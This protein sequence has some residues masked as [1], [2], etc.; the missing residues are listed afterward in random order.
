M[1]KLT[2]LFIA[3]VLL[4]ACTGTGKPDAEESKVKYETYHNDYYDYTVEYP[5][6]LIPQG[7]ATNQDGQKFFS[8]DQKIQLLVYRDYKNDFLTGGD[9]YMISEAYEEDLKGKEEIFNKELHDNHYTIE[10][11]TDDI[12]HTDYA[13]LYGE[14]Y[15]NI[16]FE[17]PETEK[18]RMEAIVEH[19]IKSFKVEDLD[20]GGDEPEGNATAGELEDSFPAFLEGFLKDCYWGKNF[21]T[22]LRNNDKTL[23]TYLDPRMDVRRYYAPG[24]VAILATRDENF[25][26]APED[27]F[28][29]RPS[30]DGDLIFEYVND[31]S[32][33]CELIYSNINVIY[34]VSIKSVPD[35]VV[36]RETLETRP[37]KI[38]YPEAQIMAV[39]LP[40]A[41]DNPVGYYFMHTPDGWKLAFVDDTLCG[42]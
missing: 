38:A 11:K 34:Y 2:T 1:K 36:N 33:P 8:D 31:D 17:Y 10:Y 3:L 18:E 27:D 9:L 15:F 24:T 37:V 40:N 39:Y 7:E 6:F 32:S 22:L 20:A 28:M 13:L 29:R 14:N 30:V 5:Y 19:V 42:A 23:A 16:R 4:S 35:V 25:G 41:Y 26:F 21:N 12:L